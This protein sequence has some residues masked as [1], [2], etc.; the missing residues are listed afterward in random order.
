MI[1]TLRG[2]LIA[3]SG[4]LII[5]EVSGIGY[6]ILVSINTSSILPK[7]GQE[8]FLYTHQ[9]IRE[10]VHVLY[11]FLQEKEKFLFCELIKIAGVG[12]KLALTILSHLTT[13][14]F[15]EVIMSKDLHKLTNIPGIGQKTAQRLIMEMQNNF[16]QKK[17]KE[18]FAIYDILINNDIIDNKILI[19]D[20]IINDVQEALIALGYKAKDAIST[21]KSIIDIDIK[22]NNQNN[23]LIDNLDEN[24]EYNAAANNNQHNI[25]Y[26]NNKNTMVEELLKKS[27]KKLAKIRQTNDQNR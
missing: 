12:G 26:L 4:L 8:V 14:Q 20:N 2:K 24:I 23:Y 18:L 17:N 3:K 5:V 13:E 25:Q 1:F 7:I 11:G 16:Q 10:E 19:S 6:G 9:I 21:V 27:L 22:N 15:I